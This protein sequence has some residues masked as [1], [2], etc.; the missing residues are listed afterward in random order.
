MGKKLDHLGAVPCVPGKGRME[1][2]PVAGVISI[3]IVQVQGS[4]GFCDIPFSSFLVNP[5]VTKRCWMSQSRHAALSMVGLQESTHISPIMRH[6]EYWAFKLQ[7][8]SSNVSAPFGT[9]L[10]IHVGML[11][12]ILWLFWS[13]WCR[14]RTDVELPC[15]RH[16]SLHKHNRCFEFECVLRN[17]DFSGCRDYFNESM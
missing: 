2:P 10:R 1:N 15:L 7:A 17:F 8:S 14:D 3:T 9:V 12:N 4:D 13:S 11:K 16:Q 6:W 5:N